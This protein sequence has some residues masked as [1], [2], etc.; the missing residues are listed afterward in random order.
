MGTFVHQSRSREDILCFR[1]GTNEPVV[2]LEGRVSDGD[3][4]VAVPVG[5]DP[6]ERRPLLRQSRRKPESFGEDEINLDVYKLGRE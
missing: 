5:P 1:K 4:V 3:V 6:V 2:L